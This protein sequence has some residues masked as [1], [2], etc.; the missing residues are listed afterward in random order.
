[1]ETISIKR[2]ILAALSY[3]PVVFLISLLGW[4][5]DDFIQFHGRQGLALFIV[6]FIFW[7]LG[8]VPLLGL[9]IPLGYLVLLVIAIIGIA[10]A[11]LGRKWVVPIIGKY[12]E[13][14]R[15]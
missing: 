4:V 8:L 12:A 6:W 3:V 10:T 14:F 5:N 13:K 15:L 1:M 2:K 7:A 9:I 11:F